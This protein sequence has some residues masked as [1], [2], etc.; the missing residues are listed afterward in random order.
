MIKSTLFHIS[1]LKKKTC[2]HI[3]IKYDDTVDPLIFL[4]NFHKFCEG[5][6]S[7]KYFTFYDLLE[8]L[9]D[10]NIVMFYKK[11]EYSPDISITPLGYDG[12]AT[13]AGFQSG[14][15]M[16]ASGVDLTSNIF[17]SFKCTIASGEHLFGN[18]LYDE[19][20]M[21]SNVV[22]DNL[23]DIRKYYRL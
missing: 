1:R 15:G 4:L 10:E 16:I 19:E 14:A 18:Y 23:E 5:D 22:I 20:N 11:L 13:I 8:S 12:R 17:D 6:Q 21:L 3:S 2:D 7:F 9:Y